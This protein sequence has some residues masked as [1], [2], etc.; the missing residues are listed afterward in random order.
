M[1]VPEWLSWTAAIAS[2]A[3]L[4]VGAAGFAMALWAAL[5]A[6]GAKEAALSAQR[7][8]LHRRASEDAET[9]LR[10][11]EAVIHVVDAEDWSAARGAITE[12]RAAFHVWAARSG[13][14]IRDAAASRMD[15][16]RVTLAALDDVLASA[17]KPSPTR[18]QAAEAG[19]KAR[20]LLAGLADL[21]GAIRAGLDEAPKGDDPHELG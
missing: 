4:V 2:M 6:R 16:V 15:G 3:G 20:A 9:L 14:L 7:A 13:D 1:R 10:K 11:A 21:S 18:A 17:R 12:L 8:V 5:N 19:Q